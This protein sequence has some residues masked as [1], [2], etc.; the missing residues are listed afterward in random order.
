[1]KLLT[2]SR[3]VL[4]YA[5]LNDASFC[6]KLMNQ[7]DYIKNIGDRNIKSIVDAEI[8]I[9]A[10]ILKSDEENEYGYY[11]IQLKDSKNKGICGL[12]NTTEMSFIDI[13]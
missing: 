12:V 3:L 2:T 7:S 11:I 6:Y 9:Q 1:M 8:F 10:R 5:T 4:D 13:G